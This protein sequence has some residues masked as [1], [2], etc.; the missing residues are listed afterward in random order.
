[1]A[2]KK[3]ILL[4]SVLLVVVIFELAEVSTKEY[5]IGTCPAFAWKG[6][7]CTDACGVKGY[8]GE[9]ICHGLNCYCQQND[10]VD[11]CRDDD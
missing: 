11:P 8:R 6:Q 10:E 5:Y 1:M 9:G 7:S 4:L 3:L 2:T